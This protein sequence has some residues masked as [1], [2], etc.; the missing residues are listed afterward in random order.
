VAIYA[1]T[2]RR[3]GERR[4]GLPSDDTQMACWTLERLV[5]DG[6]YIPGQ[7]AGLA[8]SR[9]DALDDGLVGGACR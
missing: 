9:G 7:A 1:I 2:N 3:A 8:M 4:V 5:E 6:Q